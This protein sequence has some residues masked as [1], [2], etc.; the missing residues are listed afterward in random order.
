MR[1]ASDFGPRG[2]TWTGDATLHA[3]GKAVVSNPPYRIEPTP[4]E[5]R[6][7]DGYRKR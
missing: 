6:L 5:D 4:P 7:Q 3:K 1:N 2:E